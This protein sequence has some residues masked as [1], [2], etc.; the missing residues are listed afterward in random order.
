[1]NKKKQLKKILDKYPMIDNDRN[2]ITNLIKD[3]NK[4]FIVVDIPSDLR[5]DTDIK[6][7]PIEFE[8]DSVIIYYPETNERKYI[9][10]FNT[11]RN[12]LV[13]GTFDELLNGNNIIV[14]YLLAGIKFNDIDVFFD[15]MP[16]LGYNN[17]GSAYKPISWSVM[18][19]GDYI[20]FLLPCLG[21][22]NIMITIG[23]TRD[24]KF[25]YSLKDYTNKYFQPK[26]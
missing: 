5:Y 24:K 12:E 18:Q 26:N 2:F 14:Q 7:E 4:K 6:D 1:M 19:T 16:S 3:D 20:E 25:C 23:S 9:N 21:G 15:F 22:K 11:F 10:D 13:G 17:M 8:N